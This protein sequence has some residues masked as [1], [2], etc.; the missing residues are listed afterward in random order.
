[1]TTIRKTAL[2][3]ALG[4]AVVSCKDA[5]APQVDLSGEFVLRSIGGDSL[6]TVVYQDDL[7]VQRI[8]SSYLELDHDNFTI[9]IVFMNSPVADTTKGGTQISAAQGHIV[10]NGDQVDFYFVGSPTPTPATLVDG[11]IKVHTA[12]RGDWVYRK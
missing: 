8:T 3:L 6:P 1:M 11:A 7:I 5:T 2:A 10:R 4:I 9:V 12:T